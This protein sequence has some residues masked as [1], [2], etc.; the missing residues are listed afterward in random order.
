MLILQSIFSTYT[1]S[2]KSFSNANIQTHVYPNDTF[3]KSIVS[4]TH[5]HIHVQYSLPSFM[6]KWCFSY[7]NQLYTHL[8][9]ISITM[10]YENQIFTLSLKISNTYTCTCYEISYVHVYRCM[11]MDIRYIFW[12]KYLLL[13]WDI[14][15]LPDIRYLSEVLDIYQMFTYDPCYCR[16]GS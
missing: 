6:L 3:P 9:E 7:S 10:Q 8:W 12:A 13:T 4:W 2:F 15:Y 16:R 1:C 14:R 11:S 5:W